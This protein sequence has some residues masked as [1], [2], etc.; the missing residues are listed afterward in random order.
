MQALQTENMN[1]SGGQVEEDKKDLLV[2]ATGEFEDVDE[3]RNLVLT[4]STG[5]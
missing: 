3:I 2:R 4:S 1:V 5:R